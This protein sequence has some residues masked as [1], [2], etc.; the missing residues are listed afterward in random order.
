MNTASFENK[1]C[2]L[3]CCKHEAP[4]DEHLKFVIQASPQNLLLAPFKFQLFG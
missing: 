4:H 3:C 1:V 2:I